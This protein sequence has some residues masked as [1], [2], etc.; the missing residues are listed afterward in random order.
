M[1]SVQGGGVLQTAVQGAPDCPFKSSQHF[2]A[3]VSIEH[4]LD[5]QHDVGNKSGEK[6]IGEWLASCLHLMLCF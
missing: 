6:Q 4:S 1:G 3:W 2:K 5:E